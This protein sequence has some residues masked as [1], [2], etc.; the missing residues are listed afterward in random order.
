M[1]PTRPPWATSCFWGPMQAGEA[2]CIPHSFISCSSQRCL[3]WTPSQWGSPPSFSLSS[4]NNKPTTSKTTFQLELP[5]KYAINMV[6]SRCELWLSY[7]PSY[8]PLQL[9]LLFK[10]WIS[11]LPS[12][13]SHGDT[14]DQPYIYAVIT[15]TIYFWLLLWWTDTEFAT[16]LHSSLSLQGADFLQHEA[17]SSLLAKYECAEVKLTGLRLRHLWALWSG[18]YGLSPHRGKKRSGFH[19]TKGRPE[20]WQTAGK[21]SERPRLWQAQESQVQGCSLSSEAGRWSRGRPGW[22]RGKEHHI[23]WS[24]SRDLQRWPEPY[25][26]ATVVAADDTWISGGLRRED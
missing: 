21:V 26:I 1:S 6:I 17:N 11:K 8:L 2:R 20:M 24:N 4:E 3:S 18:R 7:K 14:C 10:G 13:S 25:T 9:R 23:T 5:V 22:T 19:E 16:T 15:Y 12:N